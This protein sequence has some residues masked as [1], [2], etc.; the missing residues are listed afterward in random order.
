MFS[1]TEITSHEEISDNVIHQRLLYAYVKAAEMLHGEVLELGCGAGRG[2]E[3]VLQQCARYTGVDKNKKLLAFHRERHPEHTFIEHHMPPL[4]FLESNT[5]DFVISF[6]VIEHIQD[7]AHFLQEIHRVLKPG[8][9]AIITTPNIELS[10]TRNPWHIR[11]YTHEQLSDLIGQYFQDF[12]LKGVLGN[13]KVMAYYERNKASVEK[14]TRFDVLNLQ[15]RLP[16]AVLQ[17]PY[18]LLNR[19]NRRKLQQGNQSLVAEV[20]T[21]DYFLTDDAARG[22]D[23]FCIMQK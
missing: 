6:Q 16:R 8:G 18:D 23:F 4:N 11:E 13:E 1:T 19:L 3:M 2:F 14:I 21:A 9:K 15:Y 5:F 22:F 7:D 12:T 20:T 17:V 10:L